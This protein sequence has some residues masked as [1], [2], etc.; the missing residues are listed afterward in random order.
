MANI[1]DIAPYFGAVG[2]SLIDLDADKLGA[3]DFAGALLVYV[4]EVIQAVSDGA[5]MPAFP[6]ELK[7]GTTDRVSG[8]FKA[9]LIVA[10][11]LLTVA[12][13]QVRG[14]AAVILKY[15]VQTISQLISG[16]PV[17]PAPSSV[18]AR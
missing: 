14:K 1:K 10:N 17:P 13:F 15:V 2:Q 12:R 18:V 16:L 4:A 8:A 7:A 6:D 11:S 9:V 5:D 3:D